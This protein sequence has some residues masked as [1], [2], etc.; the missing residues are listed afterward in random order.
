MPEL[1]TDRR[2]SLKQEHECFK[3]VLTGMEEEVTCAFQ[4]Q[5]RGSL[6]CANMFTFSKYVYLITRTHPALQQLQIQNSFFLLEY[7]HLG[8]QIQIN[9]L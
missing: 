5:D 1:T 4:H 6:P 2:D 7:R 3:L 9:L 8:V